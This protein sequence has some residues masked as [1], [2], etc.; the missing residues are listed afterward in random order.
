MT[1]KIIVSFCIFFGLQAASPFG[2][3]LAQ[4]P[5]VKIKTGYVAGIK[6]KGCF[7][8]KGIPYVA[9]P[10]GPRRFLPPI[11]HDK[12]RD[13][14]SCSSFGSQSAQSGDQNHPV[15][16]SED[17]L[18]L[19]VYTPSLSP[20]AKL[21]VLVWV[22][23][24]SM[25]SGSGMGENGHAF[26]DRDSVVTVTINYRLGIFGFL[27]LGDLGGIYKTSG[28]NGLLDL[29]ASLK[30]VKANIAT[31]GGDPARVT[32]MGESAGAKLSSA[33]IVTPKAKG[34][35]SGI[36]LESGGLQCIRDE[37]TALRI[38]QRLMDQLG[39][40]KP[41]ELLKLPTDILIKAQAAVIKGAQGTN[42]FGPVMDGKVIKG[43]PYDYIVQQGKDKRA[44][45]M[46]ANQAESRVFMNSDKRLY[47]PDST[48]LSDWFGKN[49]RYSLADY[50]K[51]LPAVGNDTA[52]AT[53]ILSEYMYKMH[54]YRLAA[55][56]SK[57]DRATW[58]YRFAYSSDQYEASH[59]AELKYVWFSPEHGD[60]SSTEINFGQ[61]LHAYW[62]N[63]IR[64][65]RPGSINNVKWT[66]YNTD[67]HSVIVFDKQI[68]VE[69]LKDI[70]NN[71]KSPSAC[72]LLN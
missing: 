35:F 13:T 30:W 10:I 66:R 15:R 62:V 50:H 3:L 53:S 27:Y 41:E 60:Y 70:F 57:S 24:G 7:V 31:M 45:L 2:K 14:L 6:E 18:F 63:F 11:P 34:L 29:I 20:K 58:V 23:G 8:F 64:T 61:K 38:R 9:P 47:H 42:Y 52:A 37:R 71:P 17:G 25:T 22:H 51:R 36:I 65:G 26:A 49:Y 39:I 32:V 4:P 46:G 67:N 1:F 59:G 43:D 68:K 72:F 33:L 55:A 69:K 28:N 12:W 16:G 48:V 56:L 5:I 44:Y 40:Q 19:N 21:P 54:T